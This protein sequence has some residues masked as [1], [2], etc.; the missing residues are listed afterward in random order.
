M[1][2]VLAVLAAIGMVAGAFVYRYGMPGSGLGR[3]GDSDGDGGRASPVVCAAELDAVCDALGSAG[4][5]V[6]EPIADTAARLINARTAADARIGG[7]V[8]LDPWPAIV[9]AERTR[10]S[11]TPLFAAKDSEGL[12]ATTLV[13]VTRKG[14]AIP[15]CAA[16]VTW[17]CVGD[18]AQSPAFRFGADATTPTR[19]AIRAAAL[20]GLFGRTDWA[21]NDLDL[22]SAEGQPDPRSWIAAVDERFA[23]AAGFG[24]R[25]LENFVLQQG[26]ANAFATTGVAAA[27]APAP[28]FDVATPSPAVTIAV[29]YTPG[30]RNGRDL[31]VG[32]LRDPLRDAGWQV[33]PNARTDGLP[34]PG[35]LLALRSS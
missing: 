8:A 18:A 25:S 1:T 9:D 7:W 12:A 20:N 21:T 24:A 34:S 28:S 27:G 16:E 26:S 4:G 6:V 23:Q 3:G 10:T 15:G 31:D 19:L 5:V 30:A 29:T 35:V 32:R 2:R 33:R 11:R 17:R 13:V 14:Q 22:P